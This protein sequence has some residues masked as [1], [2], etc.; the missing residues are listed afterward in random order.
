[1]TPSIGVNGATVS[2]QWLYRLPQ[3]RPHLWHY[4]FRHRY[5]LA[6][7]GAA[8]PFSDLM[9]SRITEWSTIIMPTNPEDSSR[10]LKVYQEH[11]Q[12]GRVAHQAPAF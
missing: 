10:A 6:P 12:V 7:I 4:F 3:H 8:A 5:Q 1:M 2:S 9:V 11:Q